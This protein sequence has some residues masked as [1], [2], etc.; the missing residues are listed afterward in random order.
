MRHTVN[1][2]SGAKRRPSSRVAAT[3]TLY[4]V[5]PKSATLLGNLKLRL[6]PLQVALVIREQALLGIVLRELGHALLKPTHA[7]V[8]IGATTISTSLM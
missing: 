7:L 5:R 4:A 8:S 3:V 6:T 2:S 1:D